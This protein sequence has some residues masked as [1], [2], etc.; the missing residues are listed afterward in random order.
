MEIKDKEVKIYSN[1]ESKN[2]KNYIGIELSNGKIICGGTKYLALIEHS[3]SRYLI[4]KSKCYGSYIK[5]IIELNAEEYLIAVGR[6]IFFG[7]YHFQY[8]SRL[9]L[10]QFLKFQLIL[11]QLLGKK[12]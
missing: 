5:Q 1:L 8:F 4:K 12:K 6:I 9:V 11:L 7:K 3:R 2:E 10:I